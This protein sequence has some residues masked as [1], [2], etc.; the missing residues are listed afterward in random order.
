M[1]SEFRRLRRT[2]KHCLIVNPSPAFLLELDSPWELS[3]DVE[4]GLEKSCITVAVNDSVVAFLYGQQFP[5]YCF[6]PIDDLWQMPATFDHV[7]ILARDH[8]TAP[9]WH[10][11]SC[12]ED[13]AFVTMLLPQTVMTSRDPLFA[14]GMRENQIYTDWILDVPQVLTGSE[15]RKKMLLAARRGAPY[16]ARYINLHSAETDEQGNYLVLRKSRFI[17]PPD[18]IYRGMTLAQMRH[19]A[20][21]AADGKEKGSRDSLIYD[22]SSEIKINYQLI[23]K[24]GQVERARA[25]Y[26]NIHRPEQEKNRSKGKRPNNIKTER[27]LRATTEAEILRRLEGVALYDEYYDHIVADI[28]DYYRSDYCALTVKTIWFCCRNDLIHK[29]SYDESIALQMF[30][31]KYQT[32][33]DLV[34]GVC[35]PDDLV[36]AME[37]LYGPGGEGNKEW[38]QL[39]LIFQTA[40]ETGLLER[41]PLISI[42]HLDT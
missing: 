12:C 26:R 1:R 33:S 2:T 40:V 24:D 14:Q 6:I 5:D 20:Q 19:E 7:I 41:N 32:L 36:A 10:A 3:A 31:G 13:R 11:L 8:D 21:E 42:M 28:R 18:W 9:L 35:Q 23:R 37:A 4:D 30:C 16:A 29:I 17:V 38:L 34:G 25:Y 27:G 22:F 15:P 39:H